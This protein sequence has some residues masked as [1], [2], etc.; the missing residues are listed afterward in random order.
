MSDE[1]RVEIKRGRAGARALGARSTSMMSYAHTATEPPN[2]RSNK[3]TN[4]NKNFS[5]K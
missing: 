3:Q 5:A 1:M 4:N 2:M